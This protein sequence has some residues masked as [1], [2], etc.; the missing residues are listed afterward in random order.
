MTLKL[1]RDVWVLVVLGLFLIVTV[2]VVRGERTHSNQFEM[3]PRRTTY[4]SNPG[5]LKALHDTLNMLGY[6]VTRHLHPLTSP[7]ED[8]VLFIVTPALAVSPR[9]WDSL[10]EWVERGN[11]LIIPLSRSFV[12]MEFTTEVKTVASKPINPSFLLPDVTFEA[13]E[14]SFIVETDWEFSH[15]GAFPAPFG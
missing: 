2:F 11:L 6:N 14:G 7:P 4:S 8:G 5:G 1:S 12:D 9:E 13:P 15:S 3:L 10:R